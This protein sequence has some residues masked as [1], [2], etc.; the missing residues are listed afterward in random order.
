MSGYVPSV[1]LESAQETNFRQ[2][3]PAE[4]RHYLTS[5]GGKAGPAAKEETLRKK[6][7]EVLGLTHEADSAAAP[8]LARVKPKNSIYPEYE[9]SNMWFWGGKRFRV[10]IGKPE[11]AAPK[12]NGTYIS[13][14]GEHPGF[15][16]HYNQNQVL[17]APV[18][19]RLLDLT[20]VDIRTVKVAGGV[21]SDT[22]QGPTDVTTMM[23]S[24]PLYPV[25][26]LGVE[27]GTEGKP[28]SLQEWYQAKGP[29]W[30]NVLNSRDLL[31]VCEKLEVRTRNKKDEV[32]TDVELRANVFTFLYGQPDVEEQEE[33]EA[34]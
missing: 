17:P 15:P 4:L 9:L 26:L 19:R 1:S 30:F 22:V 18:Y 24:R 6:L 32:L 27:P 7:C 23:V 16:I 5:V 13:I 34:A 2:S 25:T 31:A 10:R 21:D 14:N 3:T 33:T 11:T 8:V 28:E 20:T 29:K 12:D